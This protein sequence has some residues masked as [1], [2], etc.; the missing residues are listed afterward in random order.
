MPTVSLNPNV[1]KQLKSIADEQGTTADALVEDAALR[2]L[3]DMERQQISQEAEAFRRKYPD[4]KK[5]YLGQYIAMHRGEVVDHDT[6]EEALWTRIRQ[7]FG[8]T[9]VLITRV[10]DAV[11]RTFTRTGF[12]FE[13]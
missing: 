11:E 4:L 6:D 1:Y 5:R 13:P 2:Y 3:W 7:R 12:R 9:P 10:E 8:R